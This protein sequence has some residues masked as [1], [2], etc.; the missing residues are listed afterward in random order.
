MAISAGL[1]RH[2]VVVVHGQGADRARGGF[3]AS[4]ANGIAGTLEQH[5]GSVERRLELRGLAR[6][7]FTV[8]PPAGSSAAARRYEFIEAFWDDAFPP[9]RP[10]VVYRWALVDGW[11]QVGST[12][13]GWLTDPANDRRGGDA[14]E[15]ERLPLPPMV[16]VAY[17]LQVLLL[18]LLLVVGYLAWVPVVGVLFV[19]SILA[20]TPGLRMWG[21]WERA[22]SALQS[23]D[24]F[25]SK[26]MGD[27]Q[28]Y[29]E[30]G[31][32]AAS[33][34][35]VLEAAVIEQLRDPGIESVTIVAHSAGCG[36]AYDAL[37]E[38]RAIPQALDQLGEGVAG[39]DRGDG[40][41]PTRLALVTLGSA[42]NRYHWLS[43]RGGTTFA[44][45]YAE[46]TLDGR[47]TGLASPE[48]ARMNGA[49]P[50]AEQQRLRERFFW[51]DIYSRLDPVPAGRLRDEAIERAAVHACQV[52]HRQVINLDNPISDH[53]SYFSNR[54]LVV[55]R[56]I[57]AISGGAYPWPLPSGKTW[58]FEG[59]RGRVARVAA[60]QTVRL[61]LVLVGLAHVLALLLVPAWRDAFAALRDGVATLAGDLPLVEA[62]SEPMRAGATLVLAF[63]SVVALLA[64]ERVVHQVFFRDLG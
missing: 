23:L 18:R 32:W 48:A 6:A 52:K 29:V 50:E 14:R 24:P 39:A 40:L 62:S 7:A 37:L 41:R 16:R 36:V 42:I 2:G 30:D 61:A 45:R 13:R 10:A 25:M 38:G 47:V 22:A 11:R 55:P 56:L 19:L 43:E 12:M 31:M 46:R 51:L 54:G 17:F 53:G 26:V 35:G 9:P 28:M 59:A 5:G 33:A 64:V 49:L 15:G 63:A 21:L 4:V 57:R 8:E 20:G 44:R 27:S 1:H 34:R 60:L 58:T 3:L